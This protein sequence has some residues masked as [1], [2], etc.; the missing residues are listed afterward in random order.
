M[1]GENEMRI[2]RKIV[3]KTKIDR[4]RS[5][6]IRESWGIQPNDEWVDRRKREGGE[7]DEH[8]T[9]MNAKRLVKISRDNITAGNQSLIKKKNRRNRLQ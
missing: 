6:K 9:R 1:S 4:I 3:G 7:W 5:K 8:V 2:L